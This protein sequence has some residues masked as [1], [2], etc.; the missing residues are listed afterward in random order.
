MPPKNI[1]VHFFV[2]R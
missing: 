2:G 1:D